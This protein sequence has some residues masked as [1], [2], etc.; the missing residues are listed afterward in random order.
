MVNWNDE[1]VMWMK[2]AYQYYWLDS[3]PI[4]D[5]VWD[6][7]GKNLKRH[8]DEV[9]HPA[10]GLVEFENMGSLHYIS[11]AKF[12]AAFPEFENA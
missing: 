3:S 10:K 7:W 6:F 12:L 4:P 2:A 5:A 8:W 11:K 1:F 9:D